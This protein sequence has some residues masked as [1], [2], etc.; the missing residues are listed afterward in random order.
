MN[1][2]TVGRRAVNPQDDGKI[3]PH[4]MFVN[5]VP[6]W[7]RRLDDAVSLWIG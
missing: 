7:Q 4:E 1:W 2:L 6:V 5:V 3:E